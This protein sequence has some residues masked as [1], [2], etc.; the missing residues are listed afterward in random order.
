MMSQTAYQ[1]NVSYNEGIAEYM[2]L[3]IGS[4]N[5]LAPRNEI[6][7]LESIQSVDTNNPAAESI[8]YIQYEGNRVAVYCL[9]EQMKLQNKSPKDNLLCAILE[10]E[11]SYISLACLEANAFSRQIVKRQPLPE[12]IQGAAG[13]IESLFIYDSNNTRDAAFIVTAESLAR[14]VAEFQHSI[15]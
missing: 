7:S 14:F 3:L 13:P 11:G 12:C 9:S 10:Y 8:G 15:E 6:I 1:N 2:S 5:I 4:I